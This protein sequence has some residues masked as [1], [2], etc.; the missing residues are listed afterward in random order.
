MLLITKLMW[1]IHELG[2]YFESSCFINLSQDSESQIEIHNSNYFVNF[3]KN[4]TC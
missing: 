4:M 2:L 1:V 3:Q